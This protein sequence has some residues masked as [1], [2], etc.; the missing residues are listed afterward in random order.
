MPESKLNTLCFDGNGMNLDTGSEQD[1][2]PPY[3]LPF[4][5]DENLIAAAKQG[6]HV[7]FAEVCNRHSI[8]IFTTVYRITKNREDAEDACQDATLN[9]FVHLNTFDGRAKFSTWLTSNSNKF[10]AHD[11]AAE[12]SPQRDLNRCTLR[13]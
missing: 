4:A 1:L 5:S 12:A 2:S 10:C 7:A 6:M 11:P 8:R 9:A 3:S 13:R